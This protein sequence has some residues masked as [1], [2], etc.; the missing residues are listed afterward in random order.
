MK[1]SISF[2][3]GTSAVTSRADATAGTLKTTHVA[4][5]SSVAGLTLSNMT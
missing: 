4:G 3:A 5:G 2:Q 1:G